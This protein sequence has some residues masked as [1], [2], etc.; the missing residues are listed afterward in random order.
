MP[1]VK[2]IPALSEQVKKIR[3][4]DYARVSSD[5]ADQLNSF[6]TQ[7]EYYTSY[8]QSQVEWEFAGLYADEAVSGTSTEKREDFQRLLEDCRAGKIDRILVKS[9]SRFARNTLDCIEAVR[10]LK[11]I[12]V[13]VKFEKEGIDT[14]NMGGEMLLSILSAAAQEES[15]SISKNLKWSYQK[16]MKAGE[17]I[18]AK[19]PAGYRLQKGVLLP[20]PKQATI[21]QRIFHQYL[22]GQSAEKIAEAWNQS[23]FCGRHW[24]PSS[25]RY[26]LSNEKYVGDALVQKNYTPPVLPL[27]EKAN[28]GEV[29]QYYIRHSHQGIVSRTEYEAAQKLLAGRR[30]LHAPKKEKQ[31]YPLSRKLRCGCCGAALHHHQNNGAVCW[32]CARHR[33]KKEWCALPILQEKEVFDSFLNLHNKL[34]ENQ[35][36]FK[37]MLSQLREWQAKSLRMQPDAVLLQNRISE[38]MK[39]NH[40]LAR[41]QAKGCIDSAVFIERSQYNRKQAEELGWKL[42]RFRKSDQTELVRKETQRLLALFEEADPLLEFSP[43]VFQSLVR[44]ITVYPKKFCFQLTNGLVLEE[45]RGRT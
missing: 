28:K 35:E 3:V 25:I 16:R 1:Q 13:T 43:A 10:E 23:H 20:D 40:S 33:K 19:A 30:L 8:I 32:V 15:L 42:R 31:Q 29:P 37:T 41:L 34:L 36:I 21:I 7:T 12:G 5:S 9:I 2:V 45:R 39:Q 38:L 26:I 4:A 18:T 17:F 6:A 11:R 44:Q 24:S 27:R 14:G 22:S